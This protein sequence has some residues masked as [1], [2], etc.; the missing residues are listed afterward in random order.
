MRKTKF[1]REVFYVTYNVR[2]ADYDGHAAAHSRVRVAYSRVRDAYSR[3]RDAYSSVRDAM[4]ILVVS[5]SWLK[6]AALVRSN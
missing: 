4:P 2:D 1:K 6:V 5:P 3:V